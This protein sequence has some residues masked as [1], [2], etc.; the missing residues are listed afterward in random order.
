[1]TKRMPEKLALCESTLENTGKNHHPKAL[2]EN[3]AGSPSEQPA[4]GYL[5]L[6]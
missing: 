3:K 1:M 5:N 2:T 6:P 4:L